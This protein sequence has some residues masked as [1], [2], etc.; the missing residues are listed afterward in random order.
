MTTGILNDVDPITLTPVKDIDDEHL[1]ILR[2][3]G[4]SRAYDVRAL[5]RWVARSPT[6]PTT[7]VAFSRQQL[8]AIGGAPI[9]EKYRDTQVNIHFVMTPMS[10]APSGVGTWSRI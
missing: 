7:R 5:R 1:L 2:V 8:D 9:A 4:H 6:D 3:Q 10:T